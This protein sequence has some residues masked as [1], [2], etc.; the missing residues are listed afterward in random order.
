M[1][2]AKRPCAGELIAVLCA[3]MHAVGANRRTSHNGL[4]GRWS[5]SVGPAGAHARVVNV[6]DRAQSQNVLERG[7]DGD[8]ICP[9]GATRQLHFQHGAW[10][11]E[12][13][14]QYRRQK[15]RVP[16]LH[17]RRGIARSTCGYSTRP[18]S[19][20]VDH[21]LGLHFQAPL[22][23]CNLVLRLDENLPILQG[24]TRHAV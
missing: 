17:H 6:T 7:R 10:S 3:S 14:R 22:K 1:S 8:R 15:R 19:I 12:A 23:N 11:V 9:N 21:F 5:E 24:G 2:F 16:W 13:I 18:I 4:N 20:T